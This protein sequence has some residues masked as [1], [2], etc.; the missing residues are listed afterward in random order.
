MKQRG[1]Y[2]HIINMTGLSSHRIPDGA[3]GGGFYCGTKYAVRAM[4]EG[5][6]QEVGGAPLGPGHAA[7][8]GARAVLTPG[9]ARRKPA[10]FRCIEDHGN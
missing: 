3:Q 9:A 8:A 1:S 6:R 4:T 5:L 7:R 2:G 10:S